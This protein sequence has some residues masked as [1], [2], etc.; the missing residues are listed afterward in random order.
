MNGDSPVFQATA[1]TG[2]GYSDSYLSYSQWSGNIGLDDARC[3][4]K[5]TGF[6]S[7]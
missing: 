4:G 1:S 7:P 3:Q 6:Q 2:N 5:D